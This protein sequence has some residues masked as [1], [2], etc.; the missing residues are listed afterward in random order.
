MI[1]KSFD[2]NW[3]E[4]CKKPRNLKK[5]VQIK[6]FKVFVILKSRQLKNFSTILIRCT[7]SSRVRLRVRHL[8]RLVP[9]PLG[10]TQGWRG[11]SSDSL[12]G[13]TNGRFDHSRCLEGG[14]RGGRRYPHLQVP[15]SGRKEQ[16]QVQDQGHQ[17]DWAFGTYRPTRNSSCQRSLGW[18]EFQQIYIHCTLR[19]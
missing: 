14:R 19:K 11:N 10:A 7:N 13:W 1:W 18:V 5:L 9:P 16:V 17:Q 2:W 4:N 12:P 6:N 8:Q 15:A 3:L